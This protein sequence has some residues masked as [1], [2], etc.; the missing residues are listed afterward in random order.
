MTAGER[1]HGETRSVSMEADGGLDGEEV[2]SLAT[3]KEHADIIAD[4]VGHP[5]G[6]SS[7]EE[8]AYTNPALDQETIRQRLSVLAEAGIVNERPREQ[9]VQCSDAPEKWFEVTDTARELFDNEGLFPTVA[10]RREYQSVTKTDR[11]K[12]VEQL[13]RTSE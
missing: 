2:L 12:E 8:L 6:A 4:I 1:E 7:F 10:W 9:E 3:K 13:P 5:A 11:I